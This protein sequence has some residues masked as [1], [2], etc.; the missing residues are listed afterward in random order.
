MEGITGL[1]DE[2]GLQAGGLAKEANLMSA[3]GQF[4][5]KGQR[6]VDV[7]RRSAR[8]DGDLEL[9]C[10]FFHPFRPTTSA[11]HEGGRRRPGPDLSCDARW[12]RS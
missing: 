3:L 6:R 11:R 7:S 12:H 8:G 9:I 2:F 10:H 5:R 4:S 1:G